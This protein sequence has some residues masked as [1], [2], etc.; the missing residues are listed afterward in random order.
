MR[1][2]CLAR[3]LRP[4]THNCLAAYGWLQEPGRAA[5]Y[6]VSVE[7]DPYLFFQTRAE[8]RDFFR[9]AS[10]RLRSRTS[11]FTAEHKRTLA[12]LAGA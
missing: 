5:R 4:H 2:H 9:A 1:C 3:L 8:A 11:R 7:D 12:A 10:A 6:W